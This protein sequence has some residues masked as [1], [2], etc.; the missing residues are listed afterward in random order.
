[1]AKSHNQ[2]IPQKKVKNR[3]ADHFTRR[4]FPNKIPSAIAKN[5]EITQQT[6]QVG[7]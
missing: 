1:M 5:Q 3:G 7:H 6:N 4:P 2:F